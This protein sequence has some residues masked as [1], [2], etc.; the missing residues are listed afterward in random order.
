MSNV[1][2]F[3]TTDAKI[4]SALRASPDGVSGADLAEQ[5][6]ISRAAIWARWA[7]RAGGSFAALSANDAPATISQA[8]AGGGG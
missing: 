2:F 1:E 6:R 7:H 3:V 4:L 8:L 5:L